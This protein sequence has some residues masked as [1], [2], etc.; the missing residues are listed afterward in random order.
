MRTP[1][2]REAQKRQ[3]KLDE[4]EAQVSSGDLVIRQMSPAEREEHMAAYKRG[5]P[6]GRPAE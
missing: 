6:A 5:G 3:E 4:I 2:E 1:Q